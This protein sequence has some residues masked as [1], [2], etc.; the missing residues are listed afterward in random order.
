MRCSAKATG[1]AA[2][3]LPLAIIAEVTLDTAAQEVVPI[4]SSGGMAL[5]GSE[6]ET[7]SPDGMHSVRLQNVRG[8][9]VYS[10]PLE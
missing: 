3:R 9:Q 10:W 6:K 1:H 2:I 5:F 4:Q 8:Q 7:S